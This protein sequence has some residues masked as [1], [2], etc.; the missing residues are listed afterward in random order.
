MLS[1]TLSDSY[2]VEYARYGSLPSV[3]KIRGEKNVP[4][5]LSG[6]RTC[7]DLF[8]RLRGN[9]TCFQVCD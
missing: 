5:V 6:M 8:A 2:N 3:K 7:K 9:R 4:R 1:G